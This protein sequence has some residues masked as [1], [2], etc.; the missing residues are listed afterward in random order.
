MA[1]LS[2]KYLFYK[3]KYYQIPLFS[4]LYNYIAQFLSSITKT[5]GDIIRWAWRNVHSFMHEYVLPVMQHGTYLSLA[6]F[7]LFAYYGGYH[8][9]SRVYAYS[10][11]LYIFS[12]MAQRTPSMR[13]RHRFIKQGIIDATADAESTMLV[14]GEIFE[15]A[16]EAR[17]AQKLADIAAG[18]IPDRSRKRAS[19]GDGGSTSAGTGSSNSVDNGSGNG[20]VQDNAEGN[21]SGDGR[22]IGNGRGQSPARDGVQTR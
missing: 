9:A 5:D 18:I 1:Q 6:N 8:R 21:G 11:A 22:N 4:R 19:N 20:N 15:A 17:Y 16:R 13:N 3:N 7:I 14:G 12:T 2:Y 10:E